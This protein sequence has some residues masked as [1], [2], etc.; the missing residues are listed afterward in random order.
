[1]E[2]TGKAS[3]A[4]SCNTNRM[5]N[6]MFDFGQ[7]IEKITASVGGGGIVSEALGGNLAE[8]LNNANID[9]SLLENIPLDQAYDVLAGAGIDPSML[10][11]GQLAE[12][13][14]QLAGSGR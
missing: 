8:L 3:S 9:P 11:D 4:S 2:V 6:Y 1:M 12:L 10:T 13:I 5:E 7:I 14:P